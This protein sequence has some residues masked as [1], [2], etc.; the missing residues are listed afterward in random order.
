MIELSPKFK[1]ALATGVTT[2][3]YPLVKIYK[4]VTID[5]P[6]NTE[7]SINLSIKETTLSNQ[8]YKPLLLN[9]PTISQS[10]DIINNKFTI[11]SVSLSISNA[12][13]DGLIFSDDIQTMLNSVCEVYY[14]ANGIDSID[15]C[16]LVYTGTIRRYSQSAETITLQLED[17]TEQKLKTQIPSTL[18]SDT[19]IYTDNNLNIPYPMVYG[20]VDK[21]PTIFNTQNFIEVEKPNQNISGLWNAVSNISYSNTNIVTGHPLLTNGWLR[22]NSALS[23][24]D[25]DFI[26]ISEYTVHHFGSSSDNNLSVNQVVYEFLNS[27]VEKPARFNINKDTFLF[28]RYQEEDNEMVGIGK[29]GI[30]TRIYRPVEK[31][32]FFA[33]NRPNIITNNINF[34]GS[35]NKFYGFYGNEL[36]TGITK[37]VIGRSSDLDFNNNYTV[38]DDL[39]DENWSEEY[40][41]N[42]ART[43][44]KPTSVNNASN[45]FDEEGTWSYQDEN[46]RQANLKSEFP[47]DYI[48]NFS[49]LTG[50]HINAQNRSGGE[51]GA[52]ARFELNNL[53]ASFPCVTKILY[54]IDYFAPS[55]IGEDSQNGANI[56]VFA[57]PSAFWVEKELIQRYDNDNISFDS[58]TFGVYNAWQRNVYQDDWTTPCEVP[59]VQHEFQTDESEKK[60]SS[61]YPLQGRDYNNIILNFDKVNTAN[62][63]QWGMPQMK[64]EGV[65]ADKISSC[66]ANLKEFYTLQDVLIVDYANKNYFASLKGR[67]D[68][69]GNVISKPQFILQDILRK[70]LNYNNI[71]ELP[72]VNIDDSWINSFTLNQQKE[73]KEVIN[74]LFKS[75]IYIPSFNSKGQFKFLPILQNI[76]DYSQF[77]TIQNDDILKYSFSFTKLEDV[78]NQIN[79]K[80]KKNYASNNLDRET[81]FGIED[82]NGNIVETLDELTESLTPDMLYD[83]GYYGTKSEDAKLEVETEYIRD[84]ITARKL[85]R[86]LLM[87]YANQHLI[88]KIDLPVSY[89]NL[90]VG[91]YIKFDDLIQEKLAFGEDYTTEHVKNGQLIYPLF[92]INKIS[93]S[94][95]K[96]SIEAVQAHRGDFGMS[97]DDLGE[98]KIPN[99][100]DG[101]IYEEEVDQDFY[102]EA[103]W[104]NGINN[105]NSGQIK[106]IIDTDQVGALDYKVWL[107]EASDDFTL[108]LFGLEAGSYSVG[109][110]DASYLVLDNLI[111]NESGYGGQILINKEFTSNT[112]NLELS[113]VLEITHQTNE[114][115]NAQLEFNQ[116]ITPEELLTGDLTGDGIVNILDLVNLMQG[117]I[118][119]VELNENQITAADMNQDGTLNV[120]DVVLLVTFI[121][122]NQ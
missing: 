32:S 35:S 46:Y 21:S 64:G 97:D 7:D 101:I 110:I 16:L 119:N 78:K 80:Y 112:D 68:N 30:P 42:D 13:Y 2:S 55:N 53:N 47:V 49:H 5:N 95:N 71:L 89:I 113:F 77:Q 25:N 102:F 36:S 109:E 90:E 105:L 48:Q 70:E 23:V 79:V 114:N 40:T 121:L 88:C 117:I 59:N 8:A 96:V 92:F 28:E 29:E 19:N 83:I 86:R 44:W 3:L 104:L 111:Q 18:T 15:D 87:W 14:C 76:T 107:T 118:G 45:T 74:E 85:Q 91:D 9:A 54:R 72:D 69:D 51:S 39:Y 1:Q 12:P 62:S 73:T 61:N 63:I 6:I 34:T 52:F 27:T 75:S 38:L 122:E 65:A 60:V 31:V 58:L 99:P 94:L 10:A 66:I 37:D 67:V 120:Q 4:G 116:V 100:Y 81:G 98:Y 82:N 41:E 115:L 43:W 20:Y 24:Y 103:S 22:R 84:S 56:R 50:L 93:K 11:S 108:G 106:A 57:E 33:L 26:P 17:L